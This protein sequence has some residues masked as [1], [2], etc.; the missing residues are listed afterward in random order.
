MRFFQKLQAGSL[1]FVLFVG[2][3]IAVLLLTFVL[4]S[5]SH[6][7]FSKKADKYIEVIEKN[8]FIMQLALKSNKEGQDVTALDSYQDDDIEASIDKKAWGVFESYTVS[9][10]FKKIQFQNT[11]LIGY[12]YNEQPPALYLKDNQRPLIIVGD[13]KIE[14]NAVLPKQGIRPG[15]ISGQSYFRNRLVFGDTK[16]SSTVLPTINA[17]TNETIE[18]L[19]KSL[20]NPNRSNIIRLS[21]NGTYS[22][23]F[24]NE[25]Q[26]IV[27]DK[28]DL[29]SISLTGNIMVLANR[30]IIVTSSSN[31][32]DIVLSAP[33][34]SIKDNVQGAFQAFASKNI[35]VGKNCILNY[36]SS[37]AV[38][39][40]ARAN[41]QSVN[42]SFLPPISIGYNSEVS[43]VI[44]Y[45]NSNK[46]RLFSPQIKI[47]ENAL[48][49]GQL[50]CEKSLEL[51]G[52][53][54]GSLFTDS[55]L[56]LENGNVYQNHL[57]KGTVNSYDLEEQYVGLGIT[58]FSP[59]KKIVKWLY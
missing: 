5:Y 31:L 22:N 17:S 29:T 50:Y 41:S 36:P 20:V 44:I 14:G 10:S 21:K 40:S 52:N 48:F 38:I 19:C 12:G 51:K 28:I 47:H 23:S 35:T 39:E 46:E 33:K 3:V 24:L 30:E 15:N 49:V 27:G 59:D 32:V 2:A 57:Y 56:A 18:K 26:F 6:I 58:G 55:F 25:T 34:I 37:L 53:L 4:L 54:I 11:A 13:A 7:L 1:Q 16:L 42:Q 45:K 9:T 43:G 8:N